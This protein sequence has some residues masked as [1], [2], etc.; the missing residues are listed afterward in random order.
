MNR[1][2]EIVVA[3]EAL[4][5]LVMDSERELSAHCGGGPFNT[6]RTIARLERPVS[7]LGCLSTDS[8]GARLRRELA[9]DGVIVDAAVTVDHPTTLALA[10]VDEDGAARYRFYT[11]GTSAPALTVEVALAAMPEAVAALHVGTLGLVL[12]PMAVALE[13][14][15][16]QVAGKALIMV[17]P[18]CRPSLIHDRGRY[19]R[20]LQ[21]ILG[22]SD[23]V[24]ASVEDLGWL[25]PTGS[26][27]GAARK[28]LGQ[29]P[30]V[31]LV[32]CGGD[33][34]LVVTRETSVPVAVR[35]T[36][37]VDTIGAGDAF[38]G[39]F[40]AW[41]HARALGPGDLGDLESLRAAARFA[42]EVAALTCERAGAS[43]LR[44]SELKG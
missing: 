15:V 17:D 35:P 40:L 32:T 2:G 3:G 24:Q 19:R 8:F 11:A 31:G 28:L 13:A 7:Y 44:L 34:A 10:T 30:R 26:P 21:R 33:G 4:V 16:A 42:C 39:A 20:R 27:I 5:D 43:P 23:V 38:G 18:N 29:G 14:V 25:E 1:G 12:E 37:V 6:A 9:G 36:D 41:W 22:S